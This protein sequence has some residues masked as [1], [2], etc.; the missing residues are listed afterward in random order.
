MAFRVQ[1][2]SVRWVSG[3][4][5]AA[6]LVFAA[7]GVRAAETDITNSIFAKRSADCAD[8]AGVYSASV[9][10]ITR[11]RKFAARLRIEPGENS[12]VLTS[13]GIPNH[14]FN[15]P[16]ANFANPVKALDVTFHIPRNPQKTGTFQKLSQRSYDAILL[17]GTPVDLLSAGCYRPQEPRADKNGNVLA[18]CRDTDPWMLDPPSYDAYFGVDQ[19]NAHAQ[20]DGRY[21]YH[22]NPNALFLDNDVS[23]PSPV[24][25]FAADGFPIY[26]TIFRDADGK[27]RRA[28]SGY[29]LKTTPRPSPPQGPGGEPDGTYLADYEFAGDGDL[30]ECNGMTVDGQYGY[31]VTTTYPWIL[32]CLVGTPDPSFDKGPPGGR[33]N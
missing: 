21:H 10:D 23:K 16:T 20:P 27:V 30:D 18:G 8:Y 3:A 22:A 33:R 11:Q 6:P 28:R 14:D 7:S 13:N 15:G 17:N 31:Y 24:I 12:C 26:G 19:H 29:R 2:V 25:G 32:K 5:I 9:E 4:L 1:A